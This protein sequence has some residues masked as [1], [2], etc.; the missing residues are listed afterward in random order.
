[1]KIINLS[2]LQHEEMS[3]RG[4][5]KYS[6]TAL[7]SN[8]LGLSEMFMHHNLLPPG[9]R[10]SAP[11]FHKLSEELIIVL[12]GTVTLIIDAEEHALQAGDI[13]GI[14]V[15]N[16]RLHYLENR[17]SRIAKFL[18]INSKTPEN[19]QVIYELNPQIK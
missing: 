3:G 11:H 5:Q 16:S 6:H 15:N 12:T 17:S 1:M 10:A 7:I 2:Q 14:A 8:K 19:D 4:E 9:R 13:V 18:V